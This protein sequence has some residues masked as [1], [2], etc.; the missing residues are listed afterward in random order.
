MSKHFQVVVDDSLDEK[1]DL[2]LHGK[3]VNIITNASELGW[4]HVFC[5][6]FFPSHVFREKWMLLLCI[7]GENDKSGLELCIPGN[8]VI[9][10]NP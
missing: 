3:N 10:P 8:L 1:I 9:A 6:V 7:S 2:D 5:M 4:P